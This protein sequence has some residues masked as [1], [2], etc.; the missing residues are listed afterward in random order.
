MQRSGWLTASLALAVLLALGFWSYRAR[1]SS[2]APGG[3]GGRETALVVAPAT[4]PSEPNTPTVNLKLLSIALVNWMDDERRGRVPTP[5]KATASQL[6]SERR[7]GW[8]TR[9]LPYMGRTDLASQLH[10]AGVSGEDVPWDDPSNRPVIDT[11]LE[12]LLT[13]DMKDRELKRDGE[14]RALTGYVGLGGVG[15]DA[16]ASLRSRGFFA[17]GRPARLDEIKDGL[18]NTAAMIE[19]RRDFGP[20]ARSGASTVRPIEAFEG[21]LVLMADGSVRTMAAGADPKVLR[22]MATISAGD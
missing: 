19:V 3:S 18:S 2:V 21:G 11:V 14:G 17:D 10:G 20:W 8:M 6:P 7:L 12:M 9:L 22:S 15:G 13:A 4:P 16:S 5:A 1:V